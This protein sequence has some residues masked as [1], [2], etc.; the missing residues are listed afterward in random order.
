[1]Y[2]KQVRDVFYEKFMFQ[3]KQKQIYIRT[4]V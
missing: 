4:F 3:D 1:M 2:R